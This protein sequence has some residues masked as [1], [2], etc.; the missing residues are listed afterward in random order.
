MKVLLQRVRQASVSV[1]DK[2]V[3]EIG[4]GL[5]LLVGIEKQDTDELAARMVDR[6]LAY[7]V[8]ADAQGKMNLSVREIGGGVLAV[9]QFTLAADT[10]KGLRPGFSRAAEPGRAEAL[11]ATFV[12][13]LR[14][15]HRPVATGIF[16]AN[17]Q[18]HLINDGPV[19]FLL[20]L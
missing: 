17:M 9:S 14:R 13:L 16:A 2:V 19:T 5:L 3:G 11:F 6:L 10:Q 4:Q 20:E 8:F 15:Q 12:E 18:V 7:R 1:G